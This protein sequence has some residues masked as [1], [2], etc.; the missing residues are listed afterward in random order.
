MRTSV[1]RV[2]PET[3]LERI[4][5]ALERELV[6]AP[7]AEILE[8]ARELGMDPSMKGSAAFLGLRFPAT[9]RLEDFF[10]MT[11][12]QGWPATWRLARTRPGLLKSEPPS[13]KPPRLPRPRKG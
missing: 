11:D 9:P 8:A 7:E 2:P 10:A 3:A 5:A 4:L 13:P 6:E 1:K 12:A